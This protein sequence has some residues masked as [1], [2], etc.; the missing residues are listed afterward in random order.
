MAARSQVP[1]TPEP[2]IRGA[3]EGPR[4]IIHPSAALLSKYLHA[5]FLPKVGFTAL[6]YLSCFKLN[7]AGVEL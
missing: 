5:E 4:L 3:A 6:T 7:D 1:N 2:G